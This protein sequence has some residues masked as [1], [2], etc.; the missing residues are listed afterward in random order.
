MVSTKLSHIPCD[1]TFVFILKTTILNEK[2]DDDGLDVD[3][4]RPLKRHGSQQSTS[5]SSSCGE[6]SPATTIDSPPSVLQEDY[7]LPSS[8]SDEDDEK[9][10][11]A[12]FSDKT[13]LI[14]SSST[15]VAPVSCGGHSAT[16]IENDNTN[17]TNCKPVQ[18]ATRNVDKVTAVTNTNNLRC[19]NSDNN[20][21]KMRLCPLPMLPWAN[22]EAVWSNMC[23]KD[24]RASLDRDINMFENHPGLQPR[25]RAI[26]LDWLIEV[27]EVY[28]L[29][30]ETYYLTVDYLDRYLTLKTSISKNQL[31]LIGITCLFVASKVEEI[32][33]PKL[34]EF[35]YV[36][37]GACTEEDILQQE[38][39]VLQ[40]LNW[41]ITPVTIMGWVSIYMQLNETTGQTQSAGIDA[42]A[43]LLLN[44]SKWSQSFIYPQFSGLDYSRTAQLID[45]SSLDIGLANFPYSIIAAAAISHIID[46][47]AALRVS[48]LDW[49]SI[50]PCAKWMEPYY[51]VL[52]EEE[53]INPI[54]LLETNDQIEMS[55][56]L[57]H[58]CPNLIKDHSHIIQTHSTSLD[59]FDKGI[60]RREQL[61]SAETMIN[62]EASPAP[63][64]SIPCPPGI[65][66]PPASNRKSIDLNI[67]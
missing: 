51:Q 50:A 47:N 54:R 29:H 46:K 11:T 30:R 60:L 43:L 66:T 7:Y 15:V 62:Q 22:R 31:Q 3:Q 38:V 24:E 42:K 58:I 20:V 1:F 10:V 53:T 67:I 12:Q 27:C 65:L 61:E 21:Y 6:L 23:R 2:N 39:L 18:M 59:L 19:V 37:D 45:L 56:G 41:S 5:S 52:E 33:P 44:S 49:A 48:G 8:S 57:S 14:S 17:T 63:T 36:T 9:M 32:Y 13:Y 55:Y 25:M 34:N 4:E 64:T 40:A 16:A 35:A 28:K 26:L